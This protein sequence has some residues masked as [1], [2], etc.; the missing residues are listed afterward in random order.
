MVI[1]IIHRNA[2]LVTNYTATLSASL[3]TGVVNR[4]LALV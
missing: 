3:R 2:Q 4:L 1:D